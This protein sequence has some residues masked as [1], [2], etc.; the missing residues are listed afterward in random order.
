MCN[1]IW[2]VDDDKIFR[3]TSERYLREI[4][5]DLQVTAFE[6]AEE[7]LAALRQQAK[8]NFPEVIFVD[9]NLPVFDG[10]DFLESLSE[11]PLQNLKQIRFYVVSSSVDQRDRERTAEYDFVSGYMVKPLDISDFREIIS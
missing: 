10:W 5:P 6:D 1:K 4:N 2:I 8:D 3:Y 7:A 9:L 11:E